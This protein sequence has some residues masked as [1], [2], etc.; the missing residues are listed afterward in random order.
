LAAAALLGFAV[1]RT[2]RADDNTSRYALRCRDAKG[3]PGGCSSQYLADALGI[4]LE[5]LEAT[6]QEANQA[7]VAQ[8]LEEGLITQEQA[9]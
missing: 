5:G 1:Y 2:A 8:A 7:A 4:S 6:Y 3:R 9:D